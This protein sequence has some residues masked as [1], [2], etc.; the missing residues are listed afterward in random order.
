MT[1]ITKG[2]GGVVFD[3][4]ESVGD[5]SRRAISE[6]AARNYESALWA[7][8]P[9]AVRTGGR[10]LVGRRIKLAMLDGEWPGYVRSHSARRGFCV[11]LDA[12]G[13]EDY[14][15]G[16]FELDWRTYGECAD[17]VLL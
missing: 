10:A 11:Q 12:V 7:Q 15:V 16:Y 8:L 5:E 13:G 1:C 14:H 2:S 3:E 9:A 17:W 6:V 4:E